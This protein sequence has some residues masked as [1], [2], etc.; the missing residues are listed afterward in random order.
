M[1]VSKTAGGGSN[2]S[3]GATHEGSAVK[4]A[5]MHRKHPKFG[6]FRGR[7]AMPRDAVEHTAM[8]RNLERFVLEQRILNPQRKRD[9]GDRAGSTTGA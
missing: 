6:Q 8:M 2:P 1:A 4:I 9:A 3:P 7:L 5:M